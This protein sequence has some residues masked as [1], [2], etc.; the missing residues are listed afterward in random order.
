MFT[1]NTAKTQNKQ[2][3]HYQHREQEAGVTVSIVTKMS[4]DDS[5]GTTLID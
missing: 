5:W 3:F 1:D 2:S 4:C